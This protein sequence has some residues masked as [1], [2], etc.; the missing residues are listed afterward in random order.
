M[1][2]FGDLDNL[3]FDATPIAHPRMFPVAS[4]EWIA[5]NPA[6]R[7]AED[8]AHV[9]LIHEEDRQQWLAWFKAIGREPSSPLVGPRLWNANLGLDAA[10]AGQG[11]ALATPLNAGSDITAGRL[12]ELFATDVR[13]GGYYLR[14]LPHRWREAN[15]SAFRA[16]IESNLKACLD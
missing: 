11:V 15:L 2:G 5:N 6:V 8:L 1:I 13:L 12:V 14:A 16:W 10:L 7:S 9:P 3:P 4:P